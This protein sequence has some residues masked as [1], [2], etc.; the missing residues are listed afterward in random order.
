MYPRDWRLFLEQGQGKEIAIAQLSAAMTAHL[1][2][3]S[4]KVFLHHDYAMKAVV[5]HNLGPDHFPLIFDA[6]DNGRALADREAHIT[7]LHHTSLGWF[8]VTVKRATESKRIYVATF[9]KT[10]LVEVTRKTRRH[11]VLRA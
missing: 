9:Y 7:F 2:A 11:V 10:N 8:Q 6:V 3:L 1:G 4:N 5:K